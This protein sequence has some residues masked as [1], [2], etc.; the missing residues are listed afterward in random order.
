MSIPGHIHVSEREPD[1]SWE[2]CTESSGLEFYRDAIDSSKPA[3]HAEAEALRA[4]SGRAATGGSNFSDFRTAVKARYGHDLPPA[5]SN[6]DVLARLRE[7]YCAMVQGSMA[8]F[9]TTH[10]LS[11]W[12]T[13]FDGGHA[14]YIAMVGGFLLWCDPEAPLGA[15]VPVRVT[16]AEVTAFVNAFSG[17]AIVAPIKALIPKPVEASHMALSFLTLTPG[18]HATVKAASNIRVEPVIASAKV[19]T[20]AAAETLPILGTVK[21]DTDPANGSNVWYVL[22]DGLVTHFT[23]K[24]NVVSI[25]PAPVATDD[26]YTKATQDAAVAKAKAEATAAEKARVAALLGL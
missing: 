1:G 8:A 15:A 9:G 20:T 17:Q 16:V 25:T 21:G 10:R 13:H 7:G 4:V 5:I 22:L 18:A 14:V 12:D 11:V 24:D 23:A 26:G 19:R 2:N 3:T 6:R